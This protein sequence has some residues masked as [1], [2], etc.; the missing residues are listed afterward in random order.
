MSLTS[1]PANVP[2][3]LPTSVAA[4]IV[5]SVADRTSALL[6]LCRTVPMPTR[7]TVVPVVGN[8]PA[9]GF[10]GPDGIKPT[11]AIE[12]EPAKLTA[13]EV[14]V[15]VALSDLFIQDTTF[16][17]WTPAR[18]EIIA[19]F[20][21]VV[22]RAALYGD[23]DT[24]PGWPQ[25]GLVADAEVVSGG[26]ALAALDAAMTRLEQ[27]GVTPT[28]I[29][30]GA[31]MRAALRQQQTAVLEPFT[32]A[33]QQIWGVPI[34][35]STHWDDSAGLALVGG[36]EGVI[37]GLRQDLTWLMTNVGVIVD[38]EGNVRSAF[39]RDETFLRCFWRLAVTIAH[40]LGPSGEPVKTLALAQVTGEE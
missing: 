28:G 14:A 12:F 7:D 40:P 34:R 20:T 26:N 32:E 18:E 8:A 3:L 5:T 25:D 11:S 33:P 19:S 38:E 13:Q 23:P 2:D 35:F 30:A 36:F 1:A 16:D 10:V 27:D 21:R 29:L 15:V 9:A 6:Q 31:Q 17:P 24:P 37:V 4:D 39:Q 22:E